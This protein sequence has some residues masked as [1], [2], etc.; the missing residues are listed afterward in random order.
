MRKKKS[1]YLISGIAPG[2][3]GVGA[4]V[5][6]L[7]LRKTAF[8]YKSIYIKNPSIS[9][10]SLLKKRQLIKLIFESTSWF[11]SFFIVQ[12]RTL[13]IR[14]SKIILIYPQYFNHYVLSVLLKNNN[15]AL[16][17]MDNSFFCIKSYN[18]LNGVE[19]LRCVDNAS[20]IDESCKPF[21]RLWSRNSAI[22]K[23]KIL[24]LFSRKIYFLSQNYQHSVLLKRVFGDEIKCDIVGMDTGEFCHQVVNDNEKKSEYDIVYHGNKDN[25]KGILYVL[26]LAK[27]LKQY[28]FLIPVSKDI[29]K[30]RLS[31]VNFENCTWESGLE[32]HVRNAKLVL[33]P[34]IWSSPIEGSLLKSIACNGNVAVYNNQY[35]FQNDIPSEAILRLNDDINF[36]TKMIDD[37]IKSNRDNSLNSREWLQSYCLE[38]DDKKIFDWSFDN[39][40][41]K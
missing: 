11:L 13:L 23:L 18:Y 24:R 4:L 25:A 28:S 17:V 30:C 41:S 35:G 2:K 40:I 33:C 5:Q 3:G 19:C 21:P 6:S 8:N 14:D 15:V 39:H 36:S 32:N 1:K 27:Y 16:Y 12:I 20:N 31:N 38:L 26:R 22:K 37:F 7:E 9:I 29:I 10:T 34:S